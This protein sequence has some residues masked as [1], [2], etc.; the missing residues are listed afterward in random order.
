MRIALVYPATDFDMQFHRD[1]LA[2]GLLFLASTIERDPDRQV[3]IFDSRHTQALPDP[4]DYGKYAVIGVTAMSMQ[5]LHAIELVKQLRANGYRGKIAFG[6]PHATVAT[7]HVKSIPE[8]DAIFLGEAE[9]SF[10]AYLSALERKEAP[11]GRAWLR[12]DAG[13]WEYT[14]DCPFVDDMDELPWPARYKFGEFIRKSRFINI[15]TSR[16]C[17]FNCNF[18][19][20][21]KRILFGKRVRRRSVD[22]IV[23]EIDD[24]IARFQ[25]NS[26]S[27]DD[28]TFTFNE[29]AVLDFC[30]R[31]RTKSCTGR[32][33]AAPISPGVR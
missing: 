20:P 27:I 6:G 14:G 30:A 26:V 5:A 18:C 28:D 9:I 33:K 2:K 11:L 15:F 29:R 4:K 31:F 23:A 19:Q 17:P 10:P 21:L 8:I 7:D 22:N 32:A 3:D 12:D 13:A 16:G 25:I 1:S 24:S